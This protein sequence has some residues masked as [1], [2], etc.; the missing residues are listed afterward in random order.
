LVGFD[1]PSSFGTVFQVRRQVWPGLDAPTQ[2]PM[3]Q[4]SDTPERLDAVRIETTEHAAARSPMLEIANAMV[5][6]YKEAFGRGPTKARAQFAGPDTLVVILENSLTAAERN[7]VKLGEHERL[8]ETRLFFQYAFEDEFRSIVE[9]VLGRRALA[10]ISGID[11]RRDVA[12]ELFTLEP[13]ND[14]P[15]SEP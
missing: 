5:R 13:Q 1:A 6:L 7:L 8:R 14:V 11:T 15:A 9:S 4:V 12:I 10:F 2:S 3:T